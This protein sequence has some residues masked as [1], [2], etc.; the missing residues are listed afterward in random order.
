MSDEYDRRRQSEGPSPDDIRDA[1]TELL[2]H[3]VP[4][5]PSMRALRTLQSA[6][7]TP[8]IDVGQRTVRSWSIANGRPR[9]GE[10]R[11]DD[12]VSGYDV[13]YRGDNPCYECGNGRLRY[14]YNAYHHISGSMRVYCPRCKD[15]KEEESW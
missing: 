14:E 6:G 11:S 5:T 15:V 2:T 10:M 9:H 1:L 4:G 8:P 7:I 13:E 3:D 12:H